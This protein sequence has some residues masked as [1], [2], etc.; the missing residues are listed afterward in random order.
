MI[1]MTHSDS[2]STIDIHTHLLNPQVRFDRPFDRFSVRFFAKRLGVDPASLRSQPYTTYVDAMARSVRES[3]HVEK[4]CLFGVDTRF[5]PSGREL[6]R[7]RTVCAM[8]EDALAV[9]RQYPDCFIPFLSVHPDRPN[10]LELI[11]RFV[12]KG[13]KGAKFLQNY[14]RID[15]NDSRLTPYYERLRQH[16]LP[17]IVHIGSEYTIASARRYEG[18]DMLELPLACGVTVIAAHMGLGRVEH[19]LLWWKNLSRRPENFDADYF[20]LLE[21]LRTHSNL[22]ADISAILV[23]L[24]ARALRH[25]SEQRNVHQ[26]ILFGTDYPVP[27]TTRFNSY[28]LTTRQ[29]REVS[30]ISN[31]FD[32][33]IAAILH[34]FPPDSPIYR[35]YRKVLPLSAR[36]NGT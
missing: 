27:F 12:E 26:K 25:L 19:K 8:T 33:Y 9:A 18:I 29:R 3:R 32:R 23:P 21:K 22:Y 13:C 1:I 16:R 6:E 2:L 34:Y 20:R 17:L 35:N 28:D 10:A 31:P 4:T 30:S 36:L 24:R 15:L 14:W 5:D 11:D 7:D